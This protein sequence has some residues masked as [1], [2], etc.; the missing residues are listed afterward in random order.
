MDNI[1]YVSIYTPRYGKPIKKIASFILDFIIIVIVFTGFLLLSS[2]IFNYD[3]KFSEY[4]K[5][6]VDSG[7]G[8]LD[9]NNKIVYCSIENAECE[10]AYRTLYSNPAFIELYGS[11]RKYWFFGPTLSM[12]IATLIFEFI[13]PLSNKKHMTIGMRLFQLAPLSNSGVKVSTLQLFI[14]FLFGRFIICGVL[15]VFAILYVMIDDGNILFS[16]ILLVLILVAN[17]VCY[18]LSHQRSLIS[19]TIAQCS[20]VDAN[21]QIFFDNTKQLAAAKAKEYEYYLKGNKYGYQHTK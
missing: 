2:Y 17:I 6:I 14:R 4:N 5:L 1:K 7:V 11:I 8:T 3:A 15:P 18:V 12:L 9:E 20:L 13:I 10:N 21:E 16:I 19:N